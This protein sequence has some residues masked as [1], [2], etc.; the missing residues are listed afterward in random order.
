VWREYR[1]EKQKLE[2]Q[3]LELECNISSKA[4]GVLRTT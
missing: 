4:G 3:L 2:K 1:A